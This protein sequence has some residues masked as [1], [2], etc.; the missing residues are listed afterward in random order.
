MAA[1]TN[2]KFF[3]MFCLIFICFFL[4][5]C[6]GSNTGKAF[7]ND[8]SHYSL[9]YGEG[10]NPENWSV[11]TISYQQVND[12]LLGVFNSSVLNQE[13][14]TIRLRVFDLNNQESED[15]L[16]LLKRN[17]VWKEGWPKN[18]GSDTIYKYFSPVYGDLD[19]NGNI[20]IVM[21]A[22]GLFDS[23]VYVWD[24]EGNIQPG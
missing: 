17:D 10:L 16:Y 5:S 21:G 2:E 11:I 23:K 13:E 12:G 15:K 18:I 9:E 22:S 4:V 7:D 8:F 3:W 1:V 20:E 6:S 24:S 19:H 14:L